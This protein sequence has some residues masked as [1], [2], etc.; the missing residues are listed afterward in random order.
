MLLH[1]KPR[2]QLHHLHHNQAQ[3]PRLQP[4]RVEKRV[5][6]HQSI[7]L[8]L[9]HKLVVEV[10]LEAVLHVLRLVVPTFPI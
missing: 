3:Q 4:H 10:P 8:R 7:Y 6:M 1:H 2:R 5:M 9:L